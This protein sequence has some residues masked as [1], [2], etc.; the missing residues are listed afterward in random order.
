MQDDGIASAI[1]NNVED[2]TADE[3][4]S[5]EGS[6]VRELHTGV[7]LQGSGEMPFCVFGAVLAEEED[8]VLCGGG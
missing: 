1:A 8:V 4:S 7:W 2:A 5:V 6:A 3:I